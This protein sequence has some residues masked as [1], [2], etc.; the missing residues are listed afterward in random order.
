MFFSCGENKT[1]ENA[2]TEGTI[3]YKATVVDENSP[4]AGFAPGSAMVNFKDNN[5]H[6]YGI[7]RFNN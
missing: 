5:L 7:D 2:L 1:S 4:M 6:V 3:E